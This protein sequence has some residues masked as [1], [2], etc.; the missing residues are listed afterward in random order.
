[1]LGFTIAKFS[2]KEI[3]QYTFMQQQNKTIEAPVTTIDSE[4][5]LVVHSY[6]YK[7]IMQLNKNEAQLLLLELCNFLNKTDETR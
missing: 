6:V 3:N 5:N 4:G 1:M 7:D 2:E